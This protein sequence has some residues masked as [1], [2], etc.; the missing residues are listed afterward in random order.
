MSG[1]KSAEGIVAP[2]TRSE[3]PNSTNRIGTEVSMRPVDAYKMA[4]MPE[5]PQW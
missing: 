5:Q 4:E 2:P 1:Q 3:G